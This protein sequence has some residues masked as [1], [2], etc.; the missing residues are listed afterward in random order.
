MSEIRHIDESELEHLRYLAEKQQDFLTYLTRKYKL[1]RNHQIT[2]SGEIVAVETLSAE[3]LAELR[4]RKAAQATDPEEV[5]KTM[6]AHPN[7]A[8][9]VGKEAGGGTPN[10][11]AAQATP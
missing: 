9:H 6:R 1:G 11:K 2:D 8:H 3:R 4:A 10:G 5:L 7:L